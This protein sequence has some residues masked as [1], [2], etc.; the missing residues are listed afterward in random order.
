MGSVRE[1]QGEPLC[2]TL[3]GARDRI[4]S[5]VSIGIQRSLGDLVAK[6]ERELAAG[7]RRIKIKIKP[8]WDLDAVRAVRARFGDDSADG[9]RQRRVHARAT[10]ITSRSSTRSI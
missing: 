2:R 7:Y 9:R 3:G 8:G 6:V 10:P 5:G 4:A 1:A